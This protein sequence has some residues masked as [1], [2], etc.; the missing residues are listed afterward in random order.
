MYNIT[1]VI[2]LICLAFLIA[3]F[4]ITLSL[5]NKNLDAI[6]EEME[7]NEKRTNKT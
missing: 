5:S 2:L 6:K 4:F 1:L 3:L 7:K